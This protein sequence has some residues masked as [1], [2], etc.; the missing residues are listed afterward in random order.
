MRLCRVV[1]VICGA[2]V[3]SV[4]LARGQGREL[5]FGLDSVTAELPGG[6]R[7]VGAVTAAPGREGGDSGGMLFQ[8]GAHIRV[9]T[10]SWFDPQQ[11]S[12]DFWVQPAWPADDTGRHTFV[13]L[14]DGDAH[15]TVFRHSDTHLLF[16]YK[17]NAA[18]WRGASV[19]TGSW[20]PGTW[21]RVSAAWRS[22]EDEGIVL[23]LSVDKQRA[24][25]T[26]AIALPDLPADTLIGCRGSVE[27]ADAV[28]DEVALRDRFTM[29]GLAPPRA[30][31]VAV[32]IDARADAGPMPRTFSFVTPWN[33]RT[34]PIPFT[35]QHPYFGRFKEAGFDLVRLVAFSENW[36]WGTR[37]ERAEDG[38]LSL[39][40]SDFDTLLDM[41]RAAGAEPYIRL[42][43]HTPVALRPEGQTHNSY[44]TPRDLDEWTAFM[45]RLVEHCNVE[46]KLGIRY[47]VTMLNEADIPIRKGT[48]TWEPILDLYERTTRVV[49]Q[50]DPTAKVGGPATCGPLPGEQEEHI[51][52]YL[53]FCKA[54]NL[55]PDFLCFH[56]YKRPCPR[57][58]E[59][60]V[61]AVKRVVAEEWPGLDPEYFLDEWNL[62]VSDA[63]QNSEYAAAYLTAAVHYQT[64]A[65]L[66]RSSIVSFNSHRSFAEMQR[67]GKTFKGGFRKGD[68][69]GSARFYAAELDLGDGPRKVLY[70]HSIA[71]KG[72]RRPYTFGRFRVTV[73]TQGCV[74]ETG[75]AQAIEY[76]GGDGSAMQVVI[77]TDGEEQ[78]VLQAHSR[79]PEWQE[80][81][82]DLSLFAGKTVD[83]EFRTDCRAAGNA[84]ADHAVW[85]SP[86]LRSGKRVVFDFCERLPDATTG[87]VL[88]SG[89]WHEREPSLP[90]IKGNV[91]TPAYFAYV[92]LNQ[93]RGD[94]LPVTLAG[95][96][97]IHESDTVGVL[98]CRD[99][100]AIRVLAW[101]FDPARADFAHAVQTSDTAVERE[102][103]LTL[104]VSPG[105]TWRCKRSLIDFDHSN[106]YTDYV[107]RGSDTNNGAYNL[108]TGKVAVVARD[109]VSDQAGK[110]RRRIALRNPAVT[111]LELEPVR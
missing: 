66:T 110:I 88:V 23:C 28:L 60:A 6:A 70:T 11:G 59:D 73:P 40:F 81:S 96:D 94:R 83:V 84:Q 48:A 76:E 20:E 86:V 109:T 58:Y 12:I 108:E 31:R 98:A 49:K 92:L 104:D 90:L 34:N 55:P 65:G 101:H 95:R 53:R 85:G 106:A 22:T 46:R 13:H 19:R 15:V 77:L 62:W 82:V 80:H 18:A 37:V 74:L 42:A 1:A 52:T 79:R 33:S 61:L 26:G 69:P 39:D 68:V 2:V 29:P 78:P 25:T 8:G 107:R 111:L 93:L 89:R 63:R 105:S 27:P 36:L 75:T 67:T 47:W 21:H 51:R 32:A 50:V 14:G 9:P 97:G 91:I 102:L 56:A 17:G 103:V 72:H 38:S 45:R 4:P 54:K 24:V 44:A 35:R 64:R 41:Y 30:T 3:C 16:V 43:Y 99:G 71:G 7:T 87:T 10:R 57:D 100:A 5:H